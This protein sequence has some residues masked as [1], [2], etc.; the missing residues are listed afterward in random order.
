M[1]VI[2]VCDNCDQTLPGGDDPTRKPEGWVHV[3]PGWIGGKL[4][5]PPC[6][7][8]WGDVVRLFFTRA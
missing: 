2:F 1:A 5:C 8:Q 4:L 3:T 7:K 6:W